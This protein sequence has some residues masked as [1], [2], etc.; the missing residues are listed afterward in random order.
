MALLLVSALAITGCERPVPVGAP[1][2]GERVVTG[3]LQRRTGARLIVPDAASRIHVVLAT[4][5]GLLYRITTP[6]RSGLAPSVTRRG[7]TVLVAL[8]P[9][10]ADGAH[11]LRIVLNR[12]VRWDLRLPAGAGEQ[13]LDLDRGRV[14]RLVVGPSGLVELRLPAPVGTVPLVLTGSIGT[15]TV[16][17]PRTTPLRLQLAGGVG[18]ALTPWTADEELPRA[19]VLTPAIWPTA[20]HRY[21][22]RARSPIGLLTL[23]RDPR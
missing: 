19:T 18:S 16:S 15:L 11:E 20:R 14:T 1:D 10:G 3:P 22:L 9:T 5:P 4:L 13:R 6:G 2:P 8:R 17:T 12:A 23:R 21:W 7:G